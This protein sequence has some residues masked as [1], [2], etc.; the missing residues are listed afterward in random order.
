MVHNCLNKRG[1]IANHFFMYYCSY[2]SECKDNDKFNYFS[3]FGIR[4]SLIKKQTKNG[5]LL[6][7]VIFL[8][9]ISK[10]QDYLVIK[11]II[12]VVNISICYRRV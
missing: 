4:F 8:L 7:C 10:L 3:L 11:L 9:Q 6:A 12:K 2:K 1:I 5:I